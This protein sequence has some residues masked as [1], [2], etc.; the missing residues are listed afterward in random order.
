MGIDNDEKDEVG[1]GLEGRF[2]CIERTSLGVLFALTGD[3]IDFED[4]GDF[5]VVDIEDLMRLADTANQ[6]A[7]EM[8]L[9]I[10]DDEKH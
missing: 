1:A 7:S 2:V 10:S 9:A 8:A 6:F 4:H 3:R 5:V